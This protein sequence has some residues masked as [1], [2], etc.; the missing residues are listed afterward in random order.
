[1]G[2]DPAAQPP[3]QGIIL[4]TKTPNLGRAQQMYST[5]HFVQSGSKPTFATFDEWYPLTFDT[6]PEEPKEFSML[7]KL[8]RMYVAYMAGDIRSPLPHMAGPAGCGKSQAAEQ[9]AELAGVKLHT[10][11]V[12]RVSPLDLEGVQMPSKN[13]D[14]LVMLPATWWTQLKEGDIVL[15]DEFLRGFPEVYNGLLDILTS[16]RVGGFVLPKVFFIAASN[17]IASYDVALEDRLLH[18][19]VKDPRNNKAEFNHLAK[20]LVDEI[21][22]LPE[23]V[24]APEMNTLLRTDVLPM[25]DLLDQFTGK[26]RRGE[27]AKGNSIRKLVGM[28]K[29]REI[30]SPSLAEL[31]DSN[32]YRAI[33]ESKYQYVVLHGKIASISAS[34]VEHAMKLVGN[35]KLTEIQKFNLDLN[36]QLI[37]MES[38]L[39]ETDKKE[40]EEADDPFID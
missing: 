29:L 40:E 19:L 15:L 21:G 4:N 2:I 8:M 11:N 10:I 23:M 3:D 39:H 1:M 6:E 22:L 31:L 34:Y 7:Q 33:H 5:F 20:I 14:K 37:E 17:S 36:L 24:K 9:L 32:N 38:A 27:H 35:D 28:A 30:T 13:N 12:S 18:M 16:R 25:F 26:A